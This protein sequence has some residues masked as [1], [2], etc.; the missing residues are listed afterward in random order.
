MMIDVKSI[1]SL[2]DRPYIIT[3]KAEVLHRYDPIFCTA[4]LIE[5]VEVIVFFDWSFTN[6]EFA[7]FERD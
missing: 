3:G 4:T 2:P 7:I 6:G 1:P 5:T